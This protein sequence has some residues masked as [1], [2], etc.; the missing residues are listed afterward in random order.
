MNKPRGRSAG[1]AIALGGLLAG[2]AGARVEV[3]ARRAAY[4]ISM[5]SSVRDD[6]GTLLDIRSLKIA[7]GFHFE[8]T[9]LG[10]LYSGVTP[11]GALDISD[12]VN[13][14]VSAA[15]G[16]AIIRLSVTVD[17]SCDVLNSLP[18]LNAIP[19]WPGCVPVVLDGLIV[20]RRP[21]LPLP[22]VPPPP[23]P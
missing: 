16:E 7:S 6:S 15:Q 10:I 18:I 9:R 13:A 22:P 2:C 19:V 8:A 5:S 12:A 4:P 20:K 3:T 23:Q 14:Q 11:R 17:E 1:L 21:P